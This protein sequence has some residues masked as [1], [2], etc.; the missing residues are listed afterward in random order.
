MGGGLSALLPDSLS[1]ART[2]HKEGTIVG[3]GPREP[4][5]RQ[6]TGRRGRRLALLSAPLTS[7]VTAER[8]QL[9]SL[10]D[11]LWPRLQSH[12]GSAVTSYTSYTYVC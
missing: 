7:V 12:W 8:A 1:M 6:G 2:V 9:R 4:G 3:A 5:I 11:E 10:R